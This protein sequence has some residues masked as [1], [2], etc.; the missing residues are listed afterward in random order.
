MRV[1]RV[2][3]QWSMNYSRDGINWNAGM[4]NFVYTLKVTSV[5]LFV[6]NAPD[7]R[8]LTIPVL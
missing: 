5:G 8:H 1:K 4:N 3:N 7:S 6:G 2:G